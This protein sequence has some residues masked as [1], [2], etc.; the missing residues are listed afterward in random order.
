M[1]VY[2]EIKETVLL[3]YTVEGNTAFS[4]MVNKE[5]GLKAQWDERSVHKTLFRDL[6]KEE[7]EQVL[8]D[9]K[10][11]LKNLQE[12]DINSDKAREA[13]FKTEVEEVYYDPENLNQ[14]QPPVTQRQI[15]PII[16]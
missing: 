16:Q 5:L 3:L 2:L 15:I 13:F 14:E 11:I 4:W 1:Q 8:L 10:Q 7:M 6:S 12:I 9:H